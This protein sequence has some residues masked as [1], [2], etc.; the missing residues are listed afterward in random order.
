MVLGEISCALAPGFHGLTKSIETLIIDL[1]LPTSE[2][3]KFVEHFS[4]DTGRESPVLLG[5][6]LTKSLEAAFG[7]HG[8]EMDEIPRFG[9][10]EYSEDFVNPE[11]LSSQ[12]RNTLACING[13]ET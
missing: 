9:S 8:S 1:R 12:G 13:K 3:V 2:V 5:S 7:L 11:F 6:L 4:E 10:T